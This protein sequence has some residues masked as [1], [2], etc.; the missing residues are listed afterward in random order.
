MDGNIKYVQ[1]RIDNNGEPVMDEFSGSGGRGQVEL[2]YSSL[3][4]WNTE[5]EAIENGK[6]TYKARVH[7]GVFAVDMDSKKIVKKCYDS[8]R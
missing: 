4:T 7:W 6:D 1:T 3:D 5:E 8:K 2:N